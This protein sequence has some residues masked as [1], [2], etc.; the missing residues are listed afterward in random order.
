MNKF[1]L[2]GKT[3]I[4]TGGAGLLGRYFCYAL[5]D[6]G[7]NIV[8]ADKNGDEAIVLRPIYSTEA[9]TAEFARLPF[10]L[11]QQMTKEI[12]K[13]PGIGTVFYDLTHKPPG[14]IEWE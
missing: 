5:A 13:I 12:L 1:D 11:L 6:F 10:E 4:V 9:M 14:T 7:A 8:V 3:A 2:T